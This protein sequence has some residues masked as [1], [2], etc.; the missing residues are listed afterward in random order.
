MADKNSLSNWLFEM[1]KNYHFQ[2]LMKMIAEKRDIAH[3]RALS[4]GETDFE[5]GR[6]HSLKWMCDLPKTIKEQSSDT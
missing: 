1:E 3:K 6:H 5:K 4:C 2:V